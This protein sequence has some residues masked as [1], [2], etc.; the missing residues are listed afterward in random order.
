MA[1]ALINK[2][3]SKLLK[4]ASEQEKQAQQQD[5]AAAKGG[6]ND[7]DEVKDEEEGKD[8]EGEED[9]SADDERISKLTEWSTDYEWVLEQ[10]EVAD[11][12]E[13]KRMSGAYTHVG[14]YVGNGEII[15]YAG[16]RN[17]P[18]GTATVRH[19][20]LLEVARGKFVL[21]FVFKHK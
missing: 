9:L 1:S 4:W 19:Q 7:G 12:V 20:S 2:G 8:V 10:L 6:T 3:K 14:L 5:A 11:I 16:D 21:K 18:F 13:F 17:V 15:D